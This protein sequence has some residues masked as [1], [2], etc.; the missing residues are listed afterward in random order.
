MVP[1]GVS[2]LER[3]P[4]ISCLSCRCFKINKWI[5]LPYSLGD[6]QTGIFVQG[7]SAN[8]FVREP[9]KSRFSVPYSSMVFLDV[10]SVYLQT[11]EFWELISPVQ[12]LEVEVL[13]VEHRLLIYQE[14][15]YIFLR[16]LLFVD[17]RCFGRFGGGL[18][19]F[20]HEQV[21]VSLTHF[22]AVLL[23]FVMRAL[24]I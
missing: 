10:I 14:K 17:C 7:S 6:F 15:S 18:F 21:S 9:C 8:E 20:W 12:D 19:L 13:G 1:T 24:F 16:S 23:S 4:K 22:D 2:A 3:D 11:Q 5:S